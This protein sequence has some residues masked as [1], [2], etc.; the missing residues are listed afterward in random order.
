MEPGCLK[1]P[2][3]FI[4][5]TQ[6]QQLQL[7]D[8]AKQSILYGLEN[9]QSLIIN[10]DQLEA[11]MQEHKASFVTLHRNGKLRGCIGVL[12]PVRP[13]ALDVAN[14]AFSAAFSD[15][16]FNAVSRNEINDLDIHISILGSSSE[17]DFNSEKDLVSQL[18]PDIDGLILSY[19]HYRGTF[20]PS[21]WES[22]KDPQVFLNHLKVK[23]GLDSSF[24]S[25][26]IKVKRY[27]VEDF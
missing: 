11:V 5:L 22:I 2:I 15:H 17:I 9:G 14:N 19:R 10:P 16:R 12:E 4:M 8:I 3:D 20:L 24:W 21:V 26:E 7:L 13:L 1:K 27:S 6:E 25:D 18:Q 23:A